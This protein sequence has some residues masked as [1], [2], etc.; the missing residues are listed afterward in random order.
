MCHERQPNWSWINVNEF[1]MS[2]G[3]S[4]YWTHKPG[5]L[6]KYL[7]NN[8]RKSCDFNGWYWTNTVKQICKLK[9]NLLWYIEAYDLRIGNIPLP[10]HSK[11]HHHVKK[12][13]WIAASAQLSRLRASGQATCARASKLLICLFSQT[14]TTGHRESPLFGQRNNF[15]GKNTAAESHHPP[16][17]LGGRT[18][19]APAVIGKIFTRSVQL[20]YLY[21]DLSA[22][23]YNFSRFSGSTA[24]FIPLQDEQP[25]TKGGLFIYICHLY[26]YLHNC[27][28]R[29]FATKLMLLDYILRRVHK[30]RKDTKSKLNA[31]CT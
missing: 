5:R 19:W 31:I 28:Y 14:V 25:V 8:R 1:L 4:E 29:V 23:N 2:P 17:Q 21:F 30:C 10:S 9:L 20:V 16:R 7:K 27:W 3:N 15:D 26:V 11:L 13:L 18:S 6:N 24:P 22:Q 12:L